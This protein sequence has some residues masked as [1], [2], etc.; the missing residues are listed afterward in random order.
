MG[1]P[2]PLFVCFCSFQTQTLRKK[3]KASEGLKASML[4]TW[5]P[6]RPHPFFDPPCPK[7]CH[8]LT[9]LCRPKILQSSVWQFSSLLNTASVWPRL[10]ILKGPSDNFSYKSSPNVWQLFWIFWKTSRFIN[11]Y[12]YFWS[13]FWKKLGN[14]LIPTLGH[15]E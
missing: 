11:C 1:Q 8:M 6:P 4:T 5:P 13:N 12:G 14:F 10:T 9:T 7:F 2:W 15:T 3:L